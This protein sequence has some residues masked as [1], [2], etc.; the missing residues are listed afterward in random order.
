M[1]AAAPTRRW[2]RAGDASPQRSMRLRAPSSRGAR[3]LLHSRARGIWR[4]RMQTLPCSA[5]HAGCQSWALD[6][7]PRA[8][9]SAAASKTTC[10]PSP[11]TSASLC[12][13]ASSRCGHLL[14]PLLFERMY[15]VWHI[16]KNVAS[17]QSVT[18]SIIL[19]VWDDCA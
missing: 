4:S 2:R 3:P 17:A 19:L 10:R 13:T 16:H 7:T 18:V 11:A 12:A 1:Q 8:G 9:Y 14:C 15:M 6:P 5:H